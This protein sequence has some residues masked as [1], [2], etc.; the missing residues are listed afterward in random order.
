MEIVQNWNII[1][2]NYLQWCINWE[3]IY[4]KIVT[5]DTWCEDIIYIDNTWTEVSW[6]WWVW[7][8]CH[9]FDYEKL[10]LCDLNGDK[11]LVESWTDSQDITQART[12]RYTYL[13]TNLPYTWDPADLSQCGWGSE[14]FDIQTKLYCDSGETVFGTL[15]FDVSWALPVLQWIVFS[16]TDWSSHTPVTPVEWACSIATSAQTITW[17]ETVTLSWSASSLTPPALTQ[18]AVW[19]VLSWT[20]VFTVDGTTPIEWSIWYIESDKFIL[21][22]DYEVANFL[23][24]WSLQTSNTAV[25]YITYYTW[26]V[27]TGWF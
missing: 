27:N 9:S 13:T 4:K 20:A 11:V 3:T 8:E 18:Y 10:L 19:Q 21:E 2:V 12:T 7:W 26:P 6:T 14:M 24:L 17:Y 16:K 23:A 22:T 5:L 15:V 25:L 1:D